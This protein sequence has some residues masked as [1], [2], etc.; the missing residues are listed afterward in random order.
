M[1]N[2]TFNKYRVLSLRLHVLPLIIWLSAVTCVV[3]LFCQRTQRFEV[4]GLAQGKIRQVA[5][6]NTGLLKSVSVELFQKVS[7]GDKIIVIDTVLENENTRA[8][9][10]AQ[11]A[12]ASA[13]IQRLMAQLLPAQEQLL[14]DAARV[15]SQK[16][17]TLRQFSIDVENGRLRILQLKTQIETDRINLENLANE[18]KIARDLLRQNAIAPYELQKAQLQYDALAKTISENENLLAQAENNL[19]DAR[20]RYFEFAKLQPQTPS[21]DS[22]LNVIQKAVKVQ[23]QKM[24]E[25]LINQVPLTL[26]SP[27]NGMVSEIYHGPGETVLAGDPILT[28]T[29]TTPTNIVAYAS[30]LQLGYIKEKMP[31]QLVKRNDPAQIA[32]SQVVYVGPK[33][34][35]MPE[36]LW[37]NTKIPQWGRPILIKIPP[38]F[39]LIPGEMV[40]VRGL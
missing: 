22:A 3:L 29:E 14:A 33:M 5:A 38:S 19:N 2:K 18:L 16:I 39:N 4:M 20:Q 13:E 30:E 34:E 27:L 15:D 37:R 9:R 35:I 26:Q 28:I 1:K 8:L 7:E 31:V 21:V 12:T 24:A 36:Q 32:A 17:V 6:A 40:G 23:E 25:L 10:Q 11:L